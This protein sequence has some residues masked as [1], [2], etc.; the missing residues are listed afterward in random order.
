[1]TGAGFLR[2][3]TRFNA[4]LAT[5]TYTTMATTLNSLNYVSSINP[6]LPAITDTNSR[7][8]VLRVNG[9]PENFIVT[10]PQFG[11]ANLRTNM[12]Y[13]NYHSMQAEFNIRPIY[14]ITN[15]ITYIW[16][17]DL[18]N[19]GAYTVPWDRAPDYRLG[20]NSRAHTLRSYG[21]YA[22]PIG[23]NQ[24]LFPNSTGVLARVAE[25]WQ[26]SWIYNAVSGIPLQ[27]TTQR[28]GWYNNPDP[29][30]VDP[31]LFDGRS[32]KVTWEQNAQFGSY[33]SGYNQVVD[34]QCRNS[35][36]VASSLQT[37]CT[38]N[39]LYDTSGNLVFRT[40]RPGEFSNFRDQIFGPG[41]WDLDMAISKR[42]K[43]NER[44]NMEIRVDG[45]N[46]LNHPQPAN[47]NLSIQGGGSPF[48]TVA[49]KSGVAV[50][51]SNYGRVFQARARLSW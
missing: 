43:I 46:I 15:S 39:A 47:P 22:L 21:T 26:V 35:A 49:S 31:T 10:S 37:L 51:F 12:G 14:G 2:A 33:F 36:I 16:A 1:L 40:P 25:G 4:N 13:R 5:G 23:P 41:D 38:L 48:G 8:N 9:L 44:I 6:S 24:L 27:V 17:K 3:D 34:P 20:T 50:Q 28:S 45:T 42:V 18:G 11:Q 7:G 29:I 19:T 32:G 30:L